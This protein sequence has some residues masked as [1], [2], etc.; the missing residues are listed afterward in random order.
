MDSMQTSPGISAVERKALEGLT[1]DLRRVFG[2]RLLSVCA[3]GLA[4]RGDG[5]PLSAL[6]L[7]ERLGFD[8]LAACAPLATD[9][10][11]HGL[12]V[13]LLLEREEFH[14]TLDV[15]PLEYGDII[16]RHVVI[17]GQDPFGGAQ[18]SPA[19]FRRAIELQA[20][21]HLIHL[22]EGFVESQ[23]NPDAVGRLVAAS[24]A[25]FRALLENIGRLDDEGDDDVAGTAER[26]IG[27]SAS[28]VREVLSA[29]T[30]G[31][32]ADPTELLARYIAAAERIWEFVDAWR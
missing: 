27:I 1:A 20:K 3:Y 7:V 15:F 5:A 32:I 22:R 6:A 24:A 23:G 30:R 14:R 29:S 10:R 25:S 4:K 18:V 21:S 2:E 9:W 8:D 19:D 28:L 26:Q 12:N 16:A 11:R 17:A 31:T 13:P